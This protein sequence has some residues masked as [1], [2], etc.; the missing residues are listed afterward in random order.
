M[1]VVEI[2][3]IQIRR[4]DARTDGM[5]QL[6]TGEFG[7]A[8]RGT[9]PT[10]TKPELY[11]GNKVTDGATANT[12][13]RILTV[14]D[15]PNIFGSSITTSTYY[16]SGHRSITVYTG[17]S[18]TNVVRT[19]K[20]K[21]DDTVSL[22]DF[23]TATDI[24]NEN[25][26]ATLQRA[27]NTVYLNSDKASPTSR[28]TLAIPAGYFAISDT[29][30]V[31]PFANIVGEGPGRTI[32]IQTVANKS[33][34]QFVDGT[35]TVGSPVTLNSMLSLS[36]P[37][38]INISDMTLV[39]GETVAV[40]SAMPLIVADCALDSTI[41]N[42]EFIGREPDAYTGAVEAYSTS[43]ASHIGLQI[44]GLSGVTSRNLRVT[45]CLFEHFNTCIQSNYDVE[46]SIIDHNRFQN[47]YYGI[48]LGIAA[49]N[50][51]GS[52]RTR[53]TRNTFYIIA[54]Q[55]VKG[56][57]TLD[58]YSG[59]ILS[60]NVYNNVGNNSSYQA[61]GDGDVGGAT[62]PVV[63]FATSG[64]VSDHD[65][66]SRS[67]EINRANADVNFITPIAGHTNII[68]NRVHVRELDNA[69]SAG[70]LVRLSYNGVSNNV[71]I[72]YQVVAS[73]LARWGELTLVCA[74]DQICGFNDIFNYT[75]T[76]DSGIIF[77]VTYDG[78]TNIILVR[79]TEN[80]VDGQII[81]QINQY[82]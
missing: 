9:A 71:R 52:L 67:I 56:T 80:A 27:I 47:S 21:L 55:A 50:T 60:Q 26:T 70:D 51:T 3:K 81:F 66:F 28:V 22:R 37:R 46:D 39:S 53:I 24:S 14:L 5:P 19:V 45:N 13:T 30:Y 82:I 73:G 48:L 7:W 75:G 6:D 57:G 38:H 58:I 1:A 65:Y 68:D 62:T 59:H 43:N 32:I 54:R 76:T 40:S 77:D 69:T 23:I 74:Q 20:A 34:F 11:I 35:S 41:H 36:Q 79:Y 72:Q 25:Y 18:S 4:G 42:V 78:G 15:L 61:I 29:I 2:A 8:I 49:G 17:P 16:Y 64:N 31:P 44:R 10:S 33:V 63:E 12:N